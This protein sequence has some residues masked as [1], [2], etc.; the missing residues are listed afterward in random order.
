VVTTPGA[1]YLFRYR[2]KNL[3]G[4]SDEYSPVAELKSAK[5]PLTPESALT[6]ISGKNVKIEW[7]PSSDNYDTVTR[8]EIEIKK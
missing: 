2:V 8:Y 3:L 5:A 4:F 1:T 6:S 7:T